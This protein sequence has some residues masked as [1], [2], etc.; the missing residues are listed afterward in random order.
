MVFFSK[1]VMNGATLFGVGLTLTAL[2]LIDGSTLWVKRVL[3]GA[4]LIY[5][6]AAFFAF[7]VPKLSE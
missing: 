3:F 1:S 4:A 5:G 2:G 7:L 6:V